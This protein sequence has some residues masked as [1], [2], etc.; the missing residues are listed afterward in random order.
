MK[1][2]IFALYGRGNIGKTSSLSM[3]IEMLQNHLITGPIEDQRVAFT[4]RGYNIA[5]TTWGDYDEE[6]D[7]NVNFLETHSWD[8]AVTSTRSRGKTCEI[9]IDYVNRIDAKLIWIPKCPNEDDVDGS[10]LQTT[11]KLYDKIDTIINKWEGIFCPRFFVEQSSSNDGTYVV[12]IM[13]HNRQEGDKQIQV[14]N[15]VY[16]TLKEAQCRA[17][18]LNKSLLEEY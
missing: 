5:I 12:S 10:N 4:Y 6:V 18:E 8:I 16:P 17:S 11:I 3:L 1:K 13:V 2:I 7:G 14:C 9:I 15:L